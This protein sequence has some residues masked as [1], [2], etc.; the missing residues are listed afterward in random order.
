MMSGLR[1]AIQPTLIPARLY[2]LDK[3]LVASTLSYPK[4]RIEGGHSS[5]ESPWKSGR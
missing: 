3:L 4:E 1:L 2:A 5:S